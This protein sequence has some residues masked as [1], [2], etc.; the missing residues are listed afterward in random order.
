MLK[1]FKEREIDF[2]WGNQGSLLK[3]SGNWICCTRKPQIFKFLMF[4][5]WLNTDTLWK[6]VFVHAHFLNVLVFCNFP[7]IR[8]RTINIQYYFLKYLHFLP[9][10][11][12]D[13]KNVFS[14]P[15][16]VLLIMF[17]IMAYFFSS[18]ESS[19]PECPRF[20][21]STVT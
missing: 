13:G 15:A 6:P 7:S 4:S 21:S 10:K 18:V 8:W 19:C 12:K 9:S 16:P 11:L 3:Y 1:W 14:K 20:E 2:H 5:A 17:W